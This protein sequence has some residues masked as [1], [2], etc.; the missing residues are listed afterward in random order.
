[1]KRLVA[2]TFLVSFSLALRSALPTPDAPPGFDVRTYGATGDG[3]TLDTAAINRAIDAAAAAGGGV[4]RFP[5]GTYFSGSIHLRSNITLSLEAGATIEA[6]PPGEGVYD[7]PEANDWTDKFHYQDF[8]HG[9]WHNSLI[10]GEGLHDVAILG[11]GLIHGTGLDAEINRFADESKGEKRYHHNPPHSGNKAIAL[12]DCHN[13]L[14]RDFSILH[15]GWF[16]ILATGVNNLVIDDLKIDTNRDGM[17]ID[18]CQNVRVARCSVNAPW[19]DAICLKASYGLGALHH[20]EDITISDCVVSGSYDEGT[21]IDGTFK[22][23][24]PEYRSW[25]SGRIKFGTESNGDFKHIAITNCIFDRCRGLAIESVDGS[26]IEDVVVS[27]LTMRHVKSSPIFIRLGARLR[28]P[29][30]T[31][32]GSIRRISITNLT[33][34]DA[35]WNL[36]SIISG[37]PG[38]PIEDISISDV[39]LVQQGGGTAELAA[40]EPPEEEKKYPEPEMFGDMPSYGFFFRHV[41][42]VTLHHVQIRTERPD[43]R[44]AMVLTDVSGAWFDHLNVA[45]DAI[46]P[47][48][49]E[50]RHVADFSVTASRGVPDTVRPALVEHEK[51]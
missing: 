22:V 37:L 42:G 9:H 3:H 2:L 8:G 32:V 35:D 39:T 47:A 12:R 17:D 6:A 24:A 5:P 4:V 50:L 38:H 1:M 26:H 27:N 43:A 34:A 21:L 51:F 48:T 14:L 30:G 15:G 44:P 7:E 19:D 49:F 18:G 25:G 20:C 16:G 13:V 28:G 11:P 40:R 33:V 10:W 46:S 31:P 45:R 29:P 36:G 23:S 41:T